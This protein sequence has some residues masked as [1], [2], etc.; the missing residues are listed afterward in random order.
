MCIKCQD[1]EKEQQKRLKWYALSLP[2]T[3]EELLLLSP[4]EKLMAKKI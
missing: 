1:L 4:I 2:Q 3:E